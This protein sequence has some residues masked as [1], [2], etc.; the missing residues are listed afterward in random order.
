MGWCTL[1]SALAAETVGRSG[2]DIVCIDLEHGLWGWDAALPSV[3]TL[4][5]AG[6]PVLVRVASH[7]PIGMMKA[8]D[9]GA[10]G[11]IVPHIETQGD[12]AAAVAACRY[13]PLGG[14]SWGPTRTSLLSEDDTNQV[15][16]RL[17]CLA[18]LESVEAIS[19]VTE[20]ATTA[21]LGGILVGSND[22]TLDMSS[23]S[24]SRSSARASQDFRDLLAAVAQACRDAGIVWAAPAGTSAEA[25]LLRELGVDVLVLPSDVALLRGAVRKEVADV[26]GW[27]SEALSFVSPFGRSLRY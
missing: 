21:G 17:V 20:I 4:S 26:H 11:V 13:P 18:M 10:D 16:A 24:L 23:A 2:V 14:R 15:N 6:L 25:E 12:A 5:A 27:E 9:A 22:L 3:L 7:E 1:G 8:L 19:N